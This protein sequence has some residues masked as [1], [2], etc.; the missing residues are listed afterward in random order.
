MLKLLNVTRAYNLDEETVI[1][2]VSGVTL[3]VGAGEFIMVIGRSGSGKT[4]LLN[5]AAGLIRPTSGQV[6]IDERDLSRMNDKELSRLRSER[7]GFVFQ[8]PSLLPSLTVLENV[9][10]PASFGKKMNKYDAVKRAASLLDQVGLS[11]KEGAY[12]KQLSAGEQKRVV[13]ARALINR[14]G[15]LLADEPTSDLDE[16]TEQEIMALLKEIN[17]D[18]VTILMVT[19][20][21]QLLPAATQVFKMEK[22]SL[23]PLSEADRILGAIESGM[24]PVPANTQK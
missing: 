7:L 11:E 9:T 14:P 4:T 5:L 2:P 6:L 19:H 17:A 12:P 3:M 10:L 22:S 15:L 8:F 20:S 13:I 1:T 24:L 18:G 23:K 16:A 21:L